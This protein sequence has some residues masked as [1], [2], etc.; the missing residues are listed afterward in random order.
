MIT[1]PTSTDFFTLWGD[2]AGEVDNARAELFIQLASNLFW[3]ATGMTDDPTD[4]NLF[5]MV[6]YAIM[7]MALYLYISREDID[8]EYAPY[9]SER[10]GSYSYS[11]SYSRVNSAVQL[12]NKTHV[13]LFDKCVDYLVEDAMHSGGG[14][15]TS[16]N[17]YPRPFVPLWEAAW[18]EFAVLLNYRRANPRWVPDGL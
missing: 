8:G 2:E 3:A 4:P 1:L 10:V 12:G 9:L 18:E 6:Q 7:D 13:M 5:N 17:L 15:A 11:K 14:W 16:T